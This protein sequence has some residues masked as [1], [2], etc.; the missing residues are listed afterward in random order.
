MILS[1]VQTFNGG[2]FVT[3]RQRDANAD[4]FQLTMQE[5]EA[6]NNGRHVT[7]TIGWIALEAGSG[8]AGDVSWL[9]GSAGGV[10]HATASVSLGASMAGGINV[11]AALS[12]YAG[13][14]SAWARGNGS[15]SATF[16][17]SVE[18]DTSQDAE[19]NHLQETVDYFAFNEMGLISGYDYDFF[20]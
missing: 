15:S 7:E 10:T 5:E 16:N 2:D 4:S 11:I 3:T 17:V 1:Q 19:T 9:A 18:E 20:A 6:L 13:A 8:T 12:S 14:D